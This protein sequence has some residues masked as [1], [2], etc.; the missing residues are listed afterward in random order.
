MRRELEEETGLKIKT[1]TQLGAYGKPE[2]D[3][4]GHTVTIAYH[5]LIDERHSHAKG[6]GDAADAKWFNIHHLPEIAFD[7]ADIIA[8]G[9]KQLP[10]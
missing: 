10:S 8:D 6:G 7:H 9:L 3:P 2:R 4:R 5:I 1:A